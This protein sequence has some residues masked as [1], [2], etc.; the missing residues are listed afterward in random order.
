M[1]FTDSI[2]RA[3][4]LCELPRGR[5]G[6]KIVQRV[7]RASG[8]AQLES[9][10][11]PRGHQQYADLVGQVFFKTNEDVLDAQDKEAI[12]AALDY[13]LSYHANFFRSSLVAFKFVGNADHRGNAD[14]NMRLSERRADAVKRTFDL[15]F[16]GYPYYVSKSEAKG[17]SRANPNQT[18]GSRRV[19]IFSNFIV[20]RDVGVAFDNYLVRG[21]YIGTKTSKFL[22]R[23]LGGGG[24]SIGPIGGN[25]VSFEIMNPRTE[26]TAIYQLLSVSGG[27][28][29]GMN[30]P[31]PDWTEVDVGAFI[32][33]DDFEGSGGIDSAGVIAGVQTL[34][35]DGPM[36]RGLTKKPVQVFMTGQDLNVGASVSL[37]GRWRRVGD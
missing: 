29:Y 15:G 37:I 1:P 14:Y 23:S 3:K 36:H 21:R 27:L 8:P 35:F 30:L 11:D 34:Y 12:G 9:W 22:I 4:Q 26:R 24:V 16:F 6:P 25:V 5:M 20:P 18:A 7:R 10:C 33:V 2:W 13:Y 31:L 28:G 19:D 17:E 32:D